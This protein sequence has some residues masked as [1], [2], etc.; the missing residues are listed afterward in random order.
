MAVLAD[1]KADAKADAEAAAVHPCPAVILCLVAGDLSMT[2]MS[3]IMW[4][5]FDRPNDQSMVLIAVW[6]NHTIWMQT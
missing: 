2:P 3:S 1:A 6:A 4:V 5:A